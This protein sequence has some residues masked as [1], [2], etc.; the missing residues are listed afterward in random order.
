MEK[1]QTIGLIAGI[2]GEILTDKLHEK[3]FKV[4]LVAGKLGESGLDKADF[5]L[6]SDLRDYNAVGEFFGEKNVKFIVI[7]TGHILALK[8]AEYLVGHGL[9]TSIDPKISLVGKNKTEY[10]KLLRSKGICTP[11]F[12][13][14]L[15]EDEVPSIST[16]VSIV[17]MPCVIKSSID[18]QLPLKANNEEEITDAINV[19]REKGSPILFERFV[20]GVDTTVPVIVHKDGSAEALMVSYYCKSKECN[21][22]GFNSEKSS[23]FETR[24]DNSTEQK[25]KRYC[26]DVAVKTGMIGLCRVDAMV[27]NGGIFILEVNSV[28]VTGVHPN[29]IE[30]G[31][32]FLKKEGVD[33]AEILVDCA[34]ERF[35]LIDKQDLGK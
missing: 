12:M 16:I 7:G 5:T 6:V 35:G 34:L 22:K 17:G 32:Y 8:L 21:L 14:V 13:E 33:F 24:L 31:N 26:E 30:Y 2:S 27:E 20:K 4:A 29:Q 19:L 11:E 18:M 10:K 9:M 3:G 28:M 1:M 15:P 23:D 25:L